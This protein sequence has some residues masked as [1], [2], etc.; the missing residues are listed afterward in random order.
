MYMDLLSVQFFLF[1]LIALGAYYGAGRFR[2]S[3]QWIVLL[4]SSLLFYAMAGSLPTILFV[5]FAA[6][7]TWLGAHAISRLDERCERE[8]GLAKGRAERKA[9]KARFAVPRRRALLLA[10]FA[11]LVVLGYVKYWNV[12]LYDFNLAPSPRSLGI[13]LPL[14]ISFFTF[15]SLSYL[16]D[17]YNGKVEPEGSF[18]RY[19]LFVAWFPQLIQGPINRFSDLAAQLY[20]ERRWDAAAARRGLLRFGYGALKKVAISNVLAGYVQSTL[21][22]VDAGTPGMVAV[23]GVLIYSIQMYADFSG[24][25]DMVEGVSE[26]FG[27]KMAQNFRQPY[28]AISLADFWRRWHMTLGTWIRDYVFYPIALTRPMK[29]IGKW[30]GKRLG[31]HAGRTLPACAANI[32]VFLIVGLWHGAEWHYVLWG[33]YN[34]IIVALADYL[35]PVFERV[36]NALHV[37]RSTRRFHVFAIVRTFAVV[38]IGR[39][40]DVI[41]TPEGIFYAL[42]NTVT[43]FKDLPF[44]MALDLYGLNIPVGALVVVGLACSFIFWVSLGYERGVD[45]RERILS[46]RLPARLA[47]YTVLAVVAAFAFGFDTSN[48]GGFLYANF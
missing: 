19:L 4:I 42:R 11:S 6:L 13:V 47:L 18:V 20:A 48:G 32:I 24:G 9:I 7:A 17:V 27:I 35:A 28:F 37:D 25:I 34:G 38:N 3:L 22:S 41:T 29:A 40:F 21:G 23:L 5:L 14:G 36:A 16:I 33:L 44:Q 46:W 10:L 1:V 8:R 2:P 31:R 39:Y 12:L 45:M 15:Q 26:L 30:A 43:A